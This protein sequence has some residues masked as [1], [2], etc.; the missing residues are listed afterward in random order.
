MVILGIESSCD[1][2]AIALVADGNKILA[3]E[4]A[5]QNDIHSLYGGVVPELASRRHLEVI[6]PL[7]NICLKKA[8]I[9][10]TDISA[11]AATTKPGLSGS[12]LIGENFGR[13]IASALEIPFLP[14]DHLEAHLSANFLPEPSPFPALGLVVSGGHS[15]IFLVT[16]PNNFE[17]LGE[18]RDDAAG[19]AFDK[20]ARLLSLPYPGGPQVEKLAEES[21]N[22]VRF[23]LPG[24][25][26]SYDFSFSGLKTAVAYYL[27]EHPDA[28][29][30]EVAAGF[31]QS[32]AEG[33]VRKLD[34]AY[35]KEPVRSVLTGGGVLANNFI[36]NLLKVWAEENT[37]E[38]R[39]PP[40][41]LC[42]DNAVMVSLRAFY[43]FH[44][45]PSSSIAR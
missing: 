45:V 9:K 41:A 15:S 13:A 35:R 44:L 19:E 37:V 3:S 39:I 17:V 40:I 42:L 1:E 2:T 34:Y 29:K 4:V 24:V 18:T 20:V 10:K 23:P 27:K 30:A 7:F 6:V 28:E 12:L 25:R 36:R 22:P 8:E 26:N 32:V 38:L 5:S 21:E 14:V 16:G 11:V 33:L 43:L 31:Q